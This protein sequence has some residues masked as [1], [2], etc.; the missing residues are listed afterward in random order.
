MKN[1]CFQSI[2]ATCVATGLLLIG[3]A[4][5]AASTWNVDSCT[6]NVLTTGC[7]TTGD[8]IRATA[9]S[10]SN[11]NSGTVLAANQ[12]FASATLSQWGANSG[13]GVKFTGETTEAP[14]H[15]MDNYG[16]TELILFNFDKSVILDAV[17]MGWTSSDADFTLMAYTGSGAPVVAGKTMSSLA[18]GWSLVQ[19]YGDA[20]ASTA[21]GYANSGTNIT[22]QVNAGGVSSS[23]W[24]VSAYN[25]A[26]GAG[27]LDTL[28]DYMKVMTIASRDPTV[29]AGGSTPEPGSLA[30]MGIAMVGFLA[31][32]KRKGRAT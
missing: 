23:W 30:L 3:N 12:V 6:V 25:S 28:A 11:T 21:T 18:S 14:E 13:L 32:R 19:N 31:S 16:Q 29:T 27:V 17:T 9:F 10:V 7:G 8:Q 15:T 20:D 4:A 2:A 1:Y 22:T 24:I 5:Q 26:Y